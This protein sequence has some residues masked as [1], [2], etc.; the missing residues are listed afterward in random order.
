MDREVAKLSGRLRF[1]AWSVGAFASLALALAAAG[2]YGVTSFLVTCRTRD[3]GVRLALGAT[4]RQVAWQVVRDGGRCIVAGTCA[5]LVCAAVSR[6][7]VASQL[8]GV[9]PG[10]ASS[11]MLAIAVLWIALAVAMLA[12]AMRAARV[13]PVISLRGD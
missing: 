2:L 7:A 13:D 4:S 5:G 1:I 3:I 6:R 8:F 12:P 10:D 11:W 9:T